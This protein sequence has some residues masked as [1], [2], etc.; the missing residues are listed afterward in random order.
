M[1]FIV[2]QISARATGGTIT[3]SRT[4]DQ[5]SLMVGRAADSDVVLEDLA[6]RLQHLKLT[7]LPGGRVG[8]E[9][10]D[11]AAVNLNGKLLDG[12]R[13]VA[14][15]AGSAITLG[16][17]KLTLTAGEKPGDVA[18]LVERLEEL[19]PARDERQIFALGA[20]MPSRRTMAWI[21]LALVLGIFLAWPLLTR[22]GVRTDTQANAAPALSVGQST[23]SSPRFVT[24]Q[25]VNAAFKPD[26]TWTSGPLS[27][28]HAFLSNN[29]GACHTKA[30]QSVRDEQCLSC[31]AGAQAGQGKSAI[32]KDHAS[33]DR[34]LKVHPEVPGFAQKLRAAVGP[35]MNL[36]Q[37]SCT[38]CHR[39]HEG[40]ITTPASSDQFCAGCH[41]NMKA[42]L[43]DTKIANA[44]SWEKHPQLHAMVQDGSA[45]PQPRFTSVALVNDQLSPAA[46]KEDSGLKFPHDV[47]LSRSNG[48]AQMA[49]TLGAKYGY[50]QSLTCAN[51]HSADT[52]G[53]RFQPVSMEKHCEACHRLEF[54][55]QNGLMRTLRHGDPQQALAD[56]RDYL[57][58]RGV[59]GSVVQ[60]DRAR[61]GLAYSERAAVRQRDTVRLYPASVP[62]TLAAV[63][64]KGGACYDCHEVSG[65]SKPGAIDYKVRPVH[66][67]ERYLVRGWFDHSDHNAANMPCQSCHAAERS[68]D[69]RDLLIPAI[70][71]GPG[72]ITGCQHCHA[73]AHPAKNQVA[74]PCASC[75]SYHSGPGA[76]AYS[77]AGASAK[78][79]RKQPGAPVAPPPPAPQQQ[80]AR[81]GATPA[82]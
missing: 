1:A 49:R 68:H 19:A 5:P 79:A 12:P 58:V 53:V 9:P 48:V 22:S 67:T 46:P 60:P 63:F 66:Q 13:D 65:P 30:F 21:G 77:R 81:I 42:Q 43:A 39:E 45:G 62:R 41:A 3:R 80:A 52:T 76:P 61:V 55:D 72:G 56:L 11:R 31:H 10:L 34:L 75:H 17:Q 20:A 54:A 2:K 7:S 50:G 27:A 16:G 82:A 4:I 29:C 23:S 37:W 28:P 35:H 24:A 47:H 33:A 6:V 64:E 32:L 51:C 18:V 74:S 15:A 57:R 25:P 26:E 59:P 73:G 70:A 44:P 40:A 71:D 69:S 8:I 38:G 36:P 14:A 78:I